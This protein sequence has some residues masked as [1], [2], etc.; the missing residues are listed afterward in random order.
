[1]QRWIKP[2]TRQGPFNTATSE[3]WGLGKGAPFFVES[4]VSWVMPEVDK[5]RKEFSRSR[6][7]LLYGIEEGLPAD[8]LR[9][10]AA[11]YLTSC[12]DLG[13]EEAKLGN[14]PY[15]TKRGE[16]VA[17]HRSVPG[18]GRFGAAGRGSSGG[19][20]STDR[21]ID[22]SAPCLPDGA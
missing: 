19:T 18:G 3:F 21:G 14:V 11:H 17:F 5:A 4:A 2:S 16:A 6:R 13:I 10:L 7:S 12:S 15:I 20:K 9:R 22:P 1:M 8:S